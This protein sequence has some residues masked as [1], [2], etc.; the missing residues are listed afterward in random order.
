[1]STHHKVN[2]KSFPFRLIEQ[3]EKTKNLVIILPGAGYT[4]QAPLLHF[5]T[6]VLYKKGFDVLHINYSFTRQ[7]MS[8][9]NDREFARDVQLTIDNAIKDKRYT[10]FFVVAKSIGT[11]ALSKL[12]HHEM[13]EDAK[14]VWLTPILQ[15]DNV[16][17]G[18]VNSD[19][20]GLCIIGDKD[21]CYIKECFEQL[22]HKQNLLLKVVQGGDHSL[23]L[24]GEPIQSIDVLK[25][26][27]S[28]ID[29]FCKP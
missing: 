15:N 20:K 21:F 19:H 17:H 11:R 16:F 9:L 24:Q 4:T 1:M 8:D 26:V 3:Q 10:S 13:F 25:N 12:L 23:E 5:T 2:S 18:M 29:E 28:A 14:L 7:E 27:I 6:G 22:K